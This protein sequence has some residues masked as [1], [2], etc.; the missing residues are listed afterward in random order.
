[1][2]SLLAPEIE[3]EV[4]AVPSENW[5]GELLLVVGEAESDENDS[6][7]GARSAAQLMQ[8]VRS[9]VAWCSANIEVEKND[10]LC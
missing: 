3:G 7:V 9:Q 4:V 2:A 1:M 5:F 10:R 8:A 6:I